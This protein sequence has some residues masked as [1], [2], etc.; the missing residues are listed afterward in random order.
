MC[1][2]GTTSM[3]NH[4]GETVAWFQIHGLPW[5]NDHGQPWF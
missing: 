5:C 4:G 1:G 2:H 3:V